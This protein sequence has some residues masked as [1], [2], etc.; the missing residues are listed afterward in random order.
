MLGVWEVRSL[1][2]L[3]KSALCEDPRTLLPPSDWSA[4]QLDSAL[5]AVLDK[6]ALVC[7]RRERQSRVVSMVT[8]DPRGVT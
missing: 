4:D 6:H 8:R 3:D 7:R 5:R 1:R 2:S